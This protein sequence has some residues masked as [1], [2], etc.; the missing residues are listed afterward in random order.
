MDQNVYRLTPCLSRDLAVSL[1]LPPGNY[2]ARTFD[3]QTGG[4]ETLP[5]LQSDGSATQEVPTFVEDTAVCL[6]LQ[7]A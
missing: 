7:K 3:P 4:E 6:E 5:T 1:N 2:T